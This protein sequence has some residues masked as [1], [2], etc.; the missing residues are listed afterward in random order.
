MRK[1][2]VHCESDYDFVYL[3]ELFPKILR[4]ITPEDSLEFRHHP[5]DGPLTK[6]TIEVAVPL[7]VDFH[8]CEVL[9][10][11][12]D[13]DGHKDKSRLISE[14]SSSI[15]QEVNPS[16]SII[17]GCPD[18]VL[19]TWFFCEADSLKKVL[20]LDAAKPIPYKGMPFKKRFDRLYREAIKNNIDISST[21]K[22]V[23]MEIARLTDPLILLK[24]DRSF[25]TFFNNTK[26]YIQ[27]G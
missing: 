14:W 4:A 9:V 18:P 25:K 19:E 11:L 16:L 10:F 2:G 7:L 22:E 1:I 12:T 5:A 13:T 3:K 21:K 15:R 24:K 20:G 26:K 23:Y 17:V 27:V 6:R 8:Q